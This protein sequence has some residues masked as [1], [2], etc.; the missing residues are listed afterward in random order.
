MK[1][2]IIKDIGENVTIADTYDKSLKMT[3]TISMITITKK[4]IKYR[5]KFN[6]NSVVKGNFQQDFLQEEIIE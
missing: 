6:A 5:A 2:K 4:G 1:E 3:G